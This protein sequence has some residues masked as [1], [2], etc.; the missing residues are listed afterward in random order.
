MAIGIFKESAMQYIVPDYYAQ[1]RC[2]ADRCKHSCCIGWE[3]DID[4]DTLEK[5]RSLPGDVG[6]ALRQSIEETEDG[7]HFRLTADERCPMLMENGLCRLI[8]AHGEESLCQICTDHP[9][10]RNF[11]PNRTETGLGL[12]CEAAASLILTRRE[13]MQ[14]I[15]LEETEDVP[16][17]PETAAFLAFRDQL[18]SIVQDRSLTMEQRLQTLLDAVSFTLPERDFL[19]VYQSLEQLDAA[20]GKLL[21][22]LPALRF[23]PLPA[24][25]AA[26][27]LPME[28]FI[29]YL[30]FRHLPAALE[31]SDIAGHTAFCV[32]SACVL[33]TL[34][35]ANPACTMD[36][37][38]DYA[39]MYSSEIEYSQENMD[40]LLDALWEDA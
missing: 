19:P 37:F 2:I 3:I 24:C 26:L 9:R 23:S 31:D 21:S 15:C 11:F 14:L 39:R 34:Y 13:P 22:A 1:F 32:L 40:A 7:A 33:L 5:Y 18:F 10:F 20:W 25:P 38:L 4:P 6:E 30:L 35:R 28:Q 29:T 12:C 16:D 17:D 27:S 8:C 36:D